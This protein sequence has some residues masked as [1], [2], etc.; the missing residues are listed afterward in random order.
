LHGPAAGKRRSLPRTSWRAPCIAKP[1]MTDLIF[2][3]VTTAFFACAWL[4]VRGCER[5]G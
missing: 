5:L 3:A 4:Y 2:I 1:A